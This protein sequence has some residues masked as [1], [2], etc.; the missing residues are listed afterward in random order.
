[1]YQLVGFNP[2][3]LGADL[4]ETARLEMYNAVTSIDNWINTV[5]KDPKSRAELVHVS[6]RPCNEQWNGPHD[7]ITNG[8]VIFRA[9]ML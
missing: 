2:K 4:T 1:M 6:A 5:A 9:C 7:Q 8:S 3:N